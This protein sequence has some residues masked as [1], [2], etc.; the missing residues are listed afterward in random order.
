[1]K[2]IKKLLSFLPAACVVL[3]VGCGTVATKHD[4]IEQV[5]LSILPTQE[6][7]P[8]IKVDKE[9]NKLPYVA[10]EN[11]YVVAKNK[12]KK[13]SVVGFIKAK[14]LFDSE[15]YENAQLAFTSLAEADKK[16]S[17]PWVFLGDIASTKGDLEGAEV[18]YQQ[19]LAVN[20]KNVN[21]YLR[22]ALAQRQQGKFI[23]AQNS[24]A[25]ALNLWPDY[26]EAHLN[27]AVLYD[28]YI[29]NPVLAQ[30]HFEAYQF[31]TFGKNNQVALWLDE[32][33]Q[34]TGIP[35]GLEVMPELPEGQLTYGN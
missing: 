6:F 35:T 30:K 27:L 21:A 3:L 9:G 16:I 15:D 33:Q 17:G 19:A 2:F 22:L 23:A 5:Q 34:R 1:M 14:R 8:E 29:N 7:I 20:P 26:P 12:V 10:A 28:I 18:N 31:L 25:E 11:P 13:E 32:L 4:A 24:Y